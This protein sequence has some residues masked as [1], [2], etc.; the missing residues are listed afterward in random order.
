MPSVMQSTTKRNFALISLLI[1]AIGLTS[2][3]AK[4]KK[5]FSLPEEFESA[6]TVFIESR[7]GDITDLKLDPEDRN[8]IL[9]MQDAVQDWGRYTLSR[10]R[11]DADLILVLH[12]GRVWRD[13]SSTAN[14]PGPH[15]ST[16]HTPIQDP[17]DASQGSSNDSPDGFKHENDELR[18]YTI[19]PDGK[20][21]GPI[22]RD[23][24]ERGLNTP[25]ILLLQRLKLEVE[26]AYPAAP[27]NKQT[28]P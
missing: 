23:D 24:L 19:Q 9:D 20:L 22:W 28:T 4:S 12:R 15:P 8:A 17:S 2:A 5:H 25:N 1:A 11:R 27:A 16:S 3:P 21:K 14:L 10:S 7:D 26:K 13:Q 18:V 6:H